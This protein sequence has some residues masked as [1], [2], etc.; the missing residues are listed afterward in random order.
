MRTLSDLIPIAALAAGLLAPASLARVVVAA[1][2]RAAVYE[3]DIRP[4]LVARCGRCHVG[5]KP[6][7]SLDLG[8][9]T[10]I[11][12][13]SETGAVVVP[14]KPEKSLLIEVLAEGSMPPDGKNP[15]TKAEVA[16]ITS[17]IRDG[18]KTRAGNFNAKAALTQEDVLPILFT[19]CVG[20]GASPGRPSCRENPV[21]ACW[22]RRSTTATCHRRNCWSI[23]GSARSRSRNSRRSAAGSLPEPPR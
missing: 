11:R 3:T 2:P 12:R 15:P 19:R 17:W 22:A 8:S 6:K 9:L 10:G 20:C 21:T 23:S 13:G 5:G 1:P 16:R 14:G 4:L 7:G 18:A